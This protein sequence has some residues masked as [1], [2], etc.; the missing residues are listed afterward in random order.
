MI[1]KGVLYLLIQIEDKSS[2]GAKSKASGHWSMLEDPE[3]IIAILVAQYALSFLKPLTLF[4]FI[5]NVV[6]KGKV[7]CCSPKLFGR[8]DIWV[9]S[10]N[11]ST[12][13]THWY[14]TTSIVSAIICALSK[15]SEN[16][17]SVLSPFSA[18]RA[19]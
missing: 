8:I 19:F 1:Y 15:S 5:V 13:P 10:V 3:F 16:F 9:I 17:S 4:E 18:L 14:N 6:R 11:L 7:H 12:Y 2:G